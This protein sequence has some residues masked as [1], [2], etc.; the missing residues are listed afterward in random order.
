M[1]RVAATSFNPVDGTIRAG[2]LQQ[3]FPLRLP[4]V[5]GFDLAGTVAAVGPGGPEELVGEDVVAF[6][7]MTEP[8]AAAEYVVAPVELLTGAPRS[9]PLADAAALPSAG[10]TAWQALTEHADLRAGQRFLVNGAGGGVGGYAVQLAADLGATVIATASPRSTAAV[11]AAGA[12]Q[13]IDY[14]RAPVVEAVTEPVDSVLNLVGTTPDELAA[15]SGLVRPGGVVVSTTTPGEDDAAREVRASSVFV[16][17]DAAQLAHLV[18]LVDAGTLQ[19][20][21]SARFPLE[22]LAEVHALG[23]AG[24]L[25]GKAVITVGES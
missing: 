1:V 22:Q 12:D 8:G 4:H 18:E 14:T 11:T 10:L 7:P 19:L 5:P 21:V 6:L 20:D 13:V 23:E 9:V 25:R 2:Y 17:S 15:L 16:R 24:G 3:V